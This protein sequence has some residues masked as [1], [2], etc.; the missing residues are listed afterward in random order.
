MKAKRSFAIL[1][2]GVTAAS[3]M[4]ISP[5]SALAD[6]GDIT[7]ASIELGTTGTDITT[8]IKL[9]THRTDMAVDDYAGKNWDA[10]LAE[11]NEMYPNITVN[12]EAVTDYAEDSLLRLQ[13][14]GWG[15]IMMI[16][17]VDMADLPEY[18]LSY[19]SSDEVSALVQ[20]TANFTYDGQVYGVPS[21]ANAQGIV[22]NKKVFEE[23]GITELPTTPEEFIEDLKLIKENTDAIPL[24]TNYAA[25]WTLGAWDAYIS[26]S[27]TGDATYLN[28]K[29]AHTE[30]PFSDPGDGTH[31]Y[32]VYKILYDAVAEGLI[33]DDYTTTDWEG[34][35]GMMNNGEIATLVL[36]SW[37]V[38]QMQGAGDNPDDVGYMPFPITVDGK[39]Y[40][41]A[42]PD[43]NFGINSKTDETQQLASMIFVKW[44]TEKSGFSQN[45]GGLPIATDDTNVPDLYSVFTDM[46]VT[47]VADDP[48][49][50]GEAD[51]MNTLNSDSELAINAGGN[52][53][54]QEIV[55]CASDGS[56]TYDEIMDSWNEAW[57][58]A[59]EDNDVE[60]LY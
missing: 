24:Y 9:L 33:E 15:D 5:M 29:L 41:T 7:Y 38:T 6:D 47:Y 31:A 16:P 26:G 50:D 20:Y 28:Q 14:E 44:F 46:D 52:S 10:Y 56:K 25:G 11:F 54:V 39:L 53:K 4:A 17:A 23:A 45:E 57:T 58:S 18:F 59:Q 35:K 49:L 12:I 27:A 34:C 51:L 40:A 32:N 3:M 43:Y 48:A 30:N 36:G 2:A 60:I 55:E 13:D 22:Y 1:M 19:G 21:T 8:E 42:G 37:A